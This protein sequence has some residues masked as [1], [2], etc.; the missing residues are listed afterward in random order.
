MPPL[1][2]NRMFHKGICAYPY[3][4]NRPFLRVLY[5]LRVHDRAKLIDPIRAT[6]GKGVL[7]INAITLLNGKHGGW[8]PQKKH[9]AQTRTAEKGDAGNVQMGNRL[10]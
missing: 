8:I 1:S 5:N 10:H 3:G 7:G 2:S 6:V 9:P 4:G